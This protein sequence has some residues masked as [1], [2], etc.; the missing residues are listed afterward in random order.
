MPY[1]RAIA[2]RRHHDA[3]HRG[4]PAWILAEQL[5]PDIEPG[6]DVPDA[7]EQRQQ[8][9]LLG[10]EWHQIGRGSQAENG[11]VVVDQGDLTV[12]Q[13]DVA[14]HRDERC[15]GRRH[16]AERIAGR[17]P[18]LRHHPVEEIRRAR[19]VA[20]QDGLGQHV[21]GFVLTNIVLVQQHRSSSFFA[22]AANTDERTARS[23]HT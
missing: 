23:G 10:Q 1:D 9:I 8:S 22:T 3:L 19:L 13:I 17:A 2:R 6:G 21:K 14:R 18:V 4:V 15:L 16:H 7:L 12:P 11:M 5:V 20:L